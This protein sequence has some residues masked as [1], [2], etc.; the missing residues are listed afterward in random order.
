ME[1]QTPAPSASNRA[2]HAACLGV[3]G[4]ALAL[5]LHVGP[6]VTAQGATARLTPSEPSI[7]PGGWVTLTLGVGGVTDLAGYQAGIDWDE[8]L[9]ELEAVEP[10]DWLGT[11]GRQIET[12]PPRVTDHSIDFLVYTLPQPPGSSVPGVGGNGDLATLRFRAIA[13]GQAVVVLRQL[14]L[15]NT[16]NEPITAD[17]EAAE[18]AIIEPT[19][20]P[21]PHIYLPYAIRSR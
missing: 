3:V 19:P 16:A 14:L 7:A 20:V 9:I 17:L 13:P 1:P 5:L 15:T 4:V 2:A 18:F 21:Q 11:T 8:A 10:T 6:A 12:I